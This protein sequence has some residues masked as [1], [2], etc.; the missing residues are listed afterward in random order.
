MC[1]IG[2]GIKWPGPDLWLTKLLLIE[3]Q[4]VLKNVFLLW[5]HGVR[6]TA[7]LEQTNEV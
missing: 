5:K 6:I 7:E 1:L 4:I 3:H 2:N